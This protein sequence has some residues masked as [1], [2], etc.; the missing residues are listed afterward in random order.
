MVSATRVTEPSGGDS[1]V[2]FT[3]ATIPS[4]RLFS[5]LHG[6][7]SKQYKALEL[8]YCVPETET[9]SSFVT[10]PDETDGTL[11]TEP[12]PPMP[13]PALGLGLQEANASEGNGERQDLP[14]RYVWRNTAGA[15]WRH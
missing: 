15:I 1:A 12:V 8:S 14:E 11:E 4:L 10:V 5:V 13:P 6:S 3:S 2:P 7:P 9:L